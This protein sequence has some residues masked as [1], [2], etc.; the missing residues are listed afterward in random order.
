MAKVT[1]TNCGPM[2]A[3][4]EGCKI[5]FDVSH[6]LYGTERCPWCGYIRKEVPVDEREGV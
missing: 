5:D 4:C 3:T 1:V 6:V 2:L